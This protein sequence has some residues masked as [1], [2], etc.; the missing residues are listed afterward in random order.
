MSEIFIDHDLILPKKRSY[1]IETIYD[2]YK[3]GHSE[4]DL[5][6]LESILKD[7]FLYEALIL[8]P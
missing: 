5:E 1:Y 6:V 7:K 8:N 4:D 3:N 2:H